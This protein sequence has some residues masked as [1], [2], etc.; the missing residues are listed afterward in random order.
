MRNQLHRRSAP[1]NL[2]ITA[3]RPQTGRPQIGRC[4]TVLSSLA[5]SLPLCPLPQALSTEDRQSYAL[6]VTIPRHGLCGTPGAL[7]FRSTTGFRP[8]A[9]LFRK[10]RPR[11]HRPKLSKQ[12]FA[13]CNAPAHACHRP[14]PRNPRGSVP[15]SDVS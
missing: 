1:R 12:P 5:V 11:H 13:H 8:G 9:F 3:V 15:V 7:R 6:L 2:C 4:Q 14:D 10:N